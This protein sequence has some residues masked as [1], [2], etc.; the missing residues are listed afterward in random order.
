M[1]GRFLNLCSH[2]LAGLSAISILDGCTSITRSEASKTEAARRQ[3]RVISLEYRADPLRT[4]EGALGSVHSDRVIVSTDLLR[5][6][7]RNGRIQQ[8]QCKN[9]SGQLEALKNVDLEET[10]DNHEEAK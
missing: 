5:S 8:S 10:G 7:V 4:L 3:E 9:I 6:L 2:F 1:N